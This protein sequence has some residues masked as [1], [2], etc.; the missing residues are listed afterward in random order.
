MLLHQSIVADYNATCPGAD[1]PDLPAACQDKLSSGNTWR[2]VAIASSV[3]GAA[4]LAGGVVLLLS[5]PS[6]AKRVALGPLGGTLGLMASGV[7]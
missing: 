7:F 1:T 4:L 3:S 5:A 2:T 6:S